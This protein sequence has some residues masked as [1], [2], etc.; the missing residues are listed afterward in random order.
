[1]YGEYCIVM[2]LI[3]IN[4]TDDYVRALIVGT[5]FNVIFVIINNFKTSL[6]HCLL[7]GGRSVGITMSV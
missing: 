5:E 3:V 1:M 4:W 6:E 2:R 7:V